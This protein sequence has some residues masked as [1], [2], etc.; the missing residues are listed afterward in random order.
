MRL[1]V[2]SDVHANRIALEAVLDDMPAVDD[3]VCAGDVVGYN[4]WPGDCVDVVRS[5]CSATVMGNHD[6]N[7][8]TPERYAANHMARAG[9]EHAQATLTDDQLAWIRSLPRSVELADGDLLLV[10]DHPTEQ[11]R[12]VMPREFPSLAPYLDDYDAVVL[13]HTHVQHAERVDGGLVCNPGSVGQPRDGDPRAGYAVLDTETTT[14][15]LHRVAYD[16]EAVRTAV[17]DAE[18]PDQTGD[19]LVEGQ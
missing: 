18:L 13:G 5:R 2:I 6:R 8:D 7:V 19:R 16:V 1:G 14:V 12:Y 9:L 17:R 15:D 4:P 11:D 10:H 3:L